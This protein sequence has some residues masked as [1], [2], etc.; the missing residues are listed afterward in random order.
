MKATRMIWP[1][2]LILA[3]A[4]A[5]FASPMT[6]S[7]TPEFSTQ[8]ISHVWHDGDMPRRVW[9]DPDLLAV[10]D[11]SGPAAEQAIRSISP[12]AEALP[13]DQTGIQLWRVPKH[14]E[15]TARSLHMLDPAAKT[16]PVLRDGPGK[17]A[18]LRALPGGVIIHLDPAWS[19]VAADDWLL[20]QHLHLT[21]KLDFGRNVFLIE[22]DAGLEALQ[23]ANQLRQ[24]HGVIAATPNWWQQLEPR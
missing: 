4:N 18:P 2:I 9:L 22:T 6:R 1:G 21:R 14:G 3:L 5:A 7:A 20:E 15:A 10:F 24:L 19:A 13:S 17:N 8:S 23:L 12:Q 11:T 16:S